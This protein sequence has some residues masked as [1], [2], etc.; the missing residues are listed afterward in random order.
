[1][2]GI[3]TQ[4]E[5]DLFRSNLPK[6]PYCRS[7]KN[8]PCKVLQ[9]EKAIQYN[10]IQPNHPYW[11][12]YFVVDID[13]NWMDVL[14]D[15]YLQPNL[16]VANRDNAKAHWFFRLETPLCK[17]D[18]GKIKPIR[19]AA[20]I[21]KCLN[22]TLGGDMG[23]NNQTAKNPLKNEH[24]RTL[25][26]RNVPYSFNELHDNLDL[27]INKQAIETETAGLG[28]NCE[29]FDRVR[30]HAYKIAKT[31]Q[32]NNDFDSFYKV[33]LNF[34]SN[35]NTFQNPLPYGEVLSITKSVS[36][37][38]YKNYNGRGKI[39]R[40]R[41]SLSQLTNL[42]DK[43]VYSAFKTNEQRKKNTEKSIR[44]AIYS[45][46]ADGQKITQK[47][48]A[49]VSGLHRNALRN[50]KNLINELKQLSTK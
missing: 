27:S 9:A 29:L 48:I 47:R 46:K 25:S 14:D 12:N 5:L 36:R 39:N 3:N 26:F 19:Y 32:N 18:N 13:T 16:I 42:N 43:Q 35:N 22:L 11:Q 4:T 20:A 45:I 44:A 6:K 40:G 31:Y 7:F 15:T 2:N 24:F 10:H 30:F 41:D 17:T 21:E 23:Y 33:L 50:Y 28:R 38:T 49:E 34:A 1:M 8:E 37:W